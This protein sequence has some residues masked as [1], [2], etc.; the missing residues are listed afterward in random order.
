[1]ALIN[2]L[3]RIAAQRGLSD[4]EVAALVSDVLGRR[5]DR[6]TVRR[7]LGGTV[8]ED[9]TLEVVAAIA[10]ALGVGLDEAV[11][12]EQSESVAMVLERAGVRV[13]QATRKGPM[14]AGFWTADPRW[15]DLV[16]P[17]L[18]DRHRDV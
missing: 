18:E 11:S 7:Y 6:R 3:G 12:L 15:G 17:F 16:T 8:I 10:Q 1:M 4:K 2:R 5:L 14:P 13:H 9:P